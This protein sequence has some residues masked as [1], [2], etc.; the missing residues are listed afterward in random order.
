MAYSRHMA[1]ILQ[2]RLFEESPALP[3][4]L[5]QVQVAENE[6]T[7]L[8]TVCKG[9]LSEYDFS[10]NPY[11]GCGFGCSY[12]YAAFFEPDPAKR[13]TWGKWVEAKSLAVGSLRRVPLLGKKLYMSSVTDPYQ[14]V[15][16]HAE[17]T[18][19]I[20]EALIP[21]RPRLTIQTRGP[22][23]TRDIDLL[24]KFEHIRVN[25]SITTDD[26]QV[27]KV[28]EPAC[29]SIEKRLEAVERL[30]A[31][32]IAVQVCVSP[33]LPMHDPEAFGK[34]LSA[35]GVTGVSAS[36][37]HTIKGD[38]AAGTREG[39]LSISAAMDWGPR[40]FRQTVQALRLGYPELDLRGEGFRPV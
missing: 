29:A 27:R 34:R 37:F 8:L 15:E 1:T 19:S 4:Q 28:Y 18:R 38:F 5:G 9:M 16:A 40:E 32:G 21:K 22:M 13:A 39:A 26:D 14:P 6:S 10:I 35:M 20:L 7:R 33:M 24:S 2:P 17:I 36:S 11:R 23:V 31:A 12:C 25:F 3:H 30:V